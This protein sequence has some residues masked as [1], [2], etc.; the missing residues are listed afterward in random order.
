M[1]CAAGSKRRKQTKPT[2]ELSLKT[3]KGRI[4]QK[5]QKMRKSSISLEGKKSME[6][7]KILSQ[8]KENLISFSF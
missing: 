1:I 2:Q 3:N 5:N 8:K 4:R 6:K 7:L